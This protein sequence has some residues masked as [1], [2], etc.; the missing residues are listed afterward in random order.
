[1]PAMRLPDFFAAAPTITVADPL[2]QTLGA[3]EDGVIEYQYADAV[4]LAGHSCPTVAGAWLM[5]RAALARLY[6]GE[7][8]RRGEIMV[9][10]EQEQGDGVAGVIANV[11]ALVTGAAGDGGFKGLGGRYARR[12]LL[13]F[14]VPLRGEMR[15]TRLD[16]GKAV[17]VSHGLSQVTRPPELGDQFSAAMAPGADDEARKRFG[18]TWQDWVREIVTTHADDPGAFV[19]SE[20]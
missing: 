19:V 1:M 14:G 5:T 11:A 17:T 18:R 10:L 8:P 3:A 15:F 12:G 2:A 7:L 16:T 6:P 9:E 13:R 4:K 20:D